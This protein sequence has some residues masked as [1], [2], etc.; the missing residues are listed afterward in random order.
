M[1]VQARPARN[2]RNSG[3]KFDERQDYRR[4]NNA[5]LMPGKVTERVIEHL[6]LPRFTGANPT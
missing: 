6:A 5:L 4:I 3:G 1:C 2:Q